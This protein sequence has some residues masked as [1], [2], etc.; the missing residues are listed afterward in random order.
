MGVVR[1][2]TYCVNHGSSEAEITSD[3]VQAEQEAKGTS[4]VQ[5]DSRTTKRTGNSISGQWNI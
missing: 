5:R 2:V 1:S 4:E 3:V